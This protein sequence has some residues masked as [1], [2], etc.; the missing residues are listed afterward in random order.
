MKKINIVVIYSVIHFIVDMSCAVL[1]SKLIT[2]TV[3]N[4]SKLVLV[5]FL[6]NLFAFAFQ[7]PFGIIADK[8]NKNALVSACGTM[9]I[10]IAFCTSKFLVF[11]SIVV[12]IGN[13]LFHIGGAIDILN[14]SNRKASFVGIYVSTGVLGL[15]LGTKNGF[16]IITYI[17]LSLLIISS[18]ILAV[19]HQKLE[20]G[21]GINKEK[22]SI[23]KAQF[24]KEIIIYPLLITI[25]IRSYLGLI[26]NYDWKQ[27][28]I[29]SVLA[30]LA[31]VFGKMLGGVLGDKFGFKKVSMVSLLMSSALFVFSF[32][33][34]IC[35]VLAI[36][37]FNMTMP[38][39][40]TVVSN[41]FEE[42]KAWHLA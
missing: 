9:L 2:P 17:A 3:P 40:C 11:S 35:G 18:I 13:A 42:K 1:L 24:S 39:T 21:S 37:M 30:I 15:Y 27:N 4:S 12:G 31:V 6:Y 33:N 14:I 23:E 28:V 36:L 29:N 5:I 19:M 16:E 41:I 7:L 10:A 20:G 26:L 34:A 32:N 8:I 38:I 22:T 25:C